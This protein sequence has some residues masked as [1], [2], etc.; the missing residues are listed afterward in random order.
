M[1]AIRIAP[2]LARR[3][4]ANPAPIDDKELPLHDSMLPVG[5]AL[6]VRAGRGVGPATLRDGLLSYVRVGD[7]AVSGSVP[8]VSSRTV[9]AGAG[10]A[11]ARAQPPS[12]QVI[13]A[14]R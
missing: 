13:L 9:R 10:C 5:A 4:E 8:D 2:S 3:P 11:P 12:C 7:R 14:P 1:R 6:H